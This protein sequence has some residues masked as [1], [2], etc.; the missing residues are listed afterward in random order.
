M[1]TLYVQNSQKTYTNPK[2]ETTRMVQQQ[3]YFSHGKTLNPYRSR[4]L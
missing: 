2:I 3:I 4:G 1:N